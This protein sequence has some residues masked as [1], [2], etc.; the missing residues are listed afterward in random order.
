MFGYIRT[1]TGDLLVREDAYY[2]ASYCGLCRAHGKCTG[3]CSRLFLSYDFTFLALVKSVLAG[4][5]PMPVGHRCLRHPFR[6]RPMLDATQSYRDTAYAAALLTAYKNADDLSDERGGKRLRAMLARP[7]LSPGKRRAGKKVSATLSCEIREQLEALRRLEEKRV[8]SV[9]QYAEAFGKL[10]GAVLSA[11]LEGDA[12]R[13]AQSVGFHIGKWV[14][15][16]D[17]ADD[18]EE[19]VKR[20]RFN[21]FACFYETD[22]LTEAHRIAIRAALTAE[23]TEAGNG[24]DL[25]TYP[26]ANDEREGIIRNVL[27]S[28]MPDVAERVL[29][30]Q[31]QSEAGTTKPEEDITQTAN[32]TETSEGKEVADSDRSV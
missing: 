18:F 3:Q 16:I 28:G 15:I 5:D 6:K 25:L 26:R 17:A 4:E 24:L 29:G 21:P 32:Q 20:G 31:L 2:R 22:H 27:E 9:D 7:L 14:Y 8:A 30:G 11:G 10:I 19:D 23:L 12:L 13:I 1:R